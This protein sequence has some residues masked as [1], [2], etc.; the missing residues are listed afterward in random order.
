MPRFTNQGH[1]EDVL[2]RHRFLY[3]VKNAPEISDSDYDAMER[4]VR[5]RWSVNNLE[6]NVGSSNA[7]DYPE[8][9]RQGRRPNASER[10]WR[11]AAIVALWMD[12]L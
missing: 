7:D 9:V 12:N 8:W 6:M 3:Y 11:D 2:L 10:V 4:E 1:A 5:Q